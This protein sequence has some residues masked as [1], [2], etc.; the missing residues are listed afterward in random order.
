[1]RISEI[2]VLPVTEVRCSDCAV[3]AQHRICSLSFTDKS[4]KMGTLSVNGL[5]EKCQLRTNHRK[6]MFCP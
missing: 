5:P 6:M 1:G 3:A 2:N 4:M